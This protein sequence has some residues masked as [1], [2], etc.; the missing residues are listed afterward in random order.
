M[1]GYSKNLGRMGRHAPRLILT[2]LLV[3]TGLAGCSRPFYRRAADREALRVIAE[4]DSLAVAPVEQFYVKPHPLARFAAPYDP[5]R[6]PMPPDDPDVASRVPNPQKP[7]RKSG[8]AW[9]EGNGYLSLLEQWDLEN[10]AARQVQSGSDTDERLMSKAK[11]VNSA[12]RPV[13]YQEKLPPPELIPPPKAPASPMTEDL[14]PHSYLISLEQALQLGLIN[15]REYQNRREDLFLTA[16]PVTLQRYSFAAQ[17]FFTEQAV[18]ERLGRQIEGQSANRWRLDSSTGFTKLFST[19]ALLVLQFA[20]QTVINLTGAN[21]HTISVSD[22]NLDIVQPLLRGAG[23]AVTLEPLT[24][25][26]RNLVYEIRSYARFRKQ[27]FVSIAAGDPLPG[28]TG[29]FGFGGGVSVGSVAGVRGGQVTPG[30]AGRVNLAT[31]RQAPGQGYLPT[32]LEAARLENEKKNVKALE[33]NLEQIRA[34][35]EGG[36]IGKLQVDRVETDLL[37]GRA[38]VLSQ[39]QIL[40]TALDQLKQQL[41][42]PVNL[43]LELDD[44]PIRP[45]TD[46]LKRF[47]QLY[48]DYSDIQDKAKEALD[49]NDPSKLR[50]RLVLLFE[51]HPIVRGTELEKSI[52]KRWDPTDKKRFNQALINRKVKEKEDL[53]LAIVLLAQIEAKGVATED[54]RKF[55]KKLGVELEKFDPASLAEKLQALRTRLQKVTPEVLPYELEYYLRRYEAKEWEK[56][57][58]QIKDARHRELLVRKEFE[59]LGQRVLIPFFLFIQEAREERLKELD[60]SWPDLPPVKVDETDLLAADQFQAQEVV[61]Q[62]AVR[63]RLDLA[64]ARAQV[65]DTW[66]QIRILANALLGVFNVRYHMD[67]STPSNLAQ[68]L[69]FGGIRTRHQLILNAELPLVRKAERNA[70]RASLI[71][72]ERARRAL[73]AAEDDVAAT[74]RNQVRQLRLLAETYKI[75]RRSVAL[76]YSQVEQANEE[77]FGPPAVGQVS[78]MRG[79]DASLTNQLLTAQ[80]SLVSSQNAVYQV[81]IDYLI[82]RMRLYRD[83]ERMPL[84]A[85]GVWVDELTSHGTRDHSPGAEQLPPPTPAPTVRLGAPR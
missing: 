76:A 32:L 8:V 12:V 37:N 50:K 78:A 72:F 62:T 80:R 11:R 3:M 52:K 68:P 25:V 31:G 61:V 46:H 15:S 44:A 64:N 81:W 21:R 27:F 53:E 38:R 10:R 71:A 47:E 4:K 16:L 14:G 55:L 63:D 39:E 48:A 41:G 73:M 66:R 33:R 13:K 54:Q 19:G 18:R 75:Q 82:F 6:P 34:Y 20:N 5:D 49:R 23:K 83:L 22:I 45:I 36:M 42:L 67:S 56:A 26:E 40:R 70:Y 28:A 51:T 9:V 57:G 2:V 69:R 7:Y 17:F 79:A 29:Q 35:S 65:V 84:D 59:R 24:Q 58:A 43:Q 74:V 1:R 77:L 60:E 85:R 30:G